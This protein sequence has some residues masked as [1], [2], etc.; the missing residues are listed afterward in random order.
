MVIL[1]SSEEIKMMRE[2]SSI[3]ADVLS[4]LKDLIEPGL[5]TLE[6]DK[7]AESETLKKGAKPAFKGYR[8]FP[9]SLCVSVNSEVVHGFPSKR[10]LREGD[11]VSIDFGVL[12]K[13]YYGDSAVT[14]AVGKI[15]KEASNLLSVT[16]KSLYR[17]I[18]K[19]I[20]GNR[21]GDVSCAIQKEAESA[22]YSVVRDFVGHGIGRA[23][24]EDPQV[25][26]YGI[27]GR[28][29]ELKA[30]LVIAIEPMINEGTFEVRVKPN[31]WTVV[32]SDERL[33]AH[34]EH[35][36]AVT[37]NGPCILSK[38]ATSH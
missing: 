1:K 10:S 18:D 27:K 3:V 36:V 13:G 16:K 35:T 24:H 5:A 14:F 26:N 30:G 29:M 15:S 6:L 34:Y 23:L 38:T 21:L 25:P 4:G 31:G 12:Y 2:S 28:G 9:Y 20:P 19:A 7:Y 17:G 22:G 32:T 37:E 8:N 33:S 11:I